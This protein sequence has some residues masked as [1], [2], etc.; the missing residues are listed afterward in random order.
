LDRPDGLYPAALTVTTACAATARIRRTIHC[1]A[2]RSRPKRSER[3]GLRK[4][5]Q[6]SLPPGLEPKTVV[7]THRMPHV[8]WEDFVA[9]GWA[10]RN[11]VKDAGDTRIRL[12]SS[13]RAARSGQSLNF[14]P[15]CNALS[16]TVSSRFGY[17]KPCLGCGAASW[18]EPVATC[19]TWTQRLGLDSEDSTEII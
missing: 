12:A 11:V 1:W 18:R 5:T 4:G 17:S 6:Q 7:N 14:R 16:Q 13:A 19:S 8:A 2:S 9:W 10:K 15:S 3:A